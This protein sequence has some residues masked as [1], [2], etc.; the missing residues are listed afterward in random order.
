MRAKERGG[1]CRKERNPAEWLKGSTFGLS[2]KYKIFQRFCKTNSQPE[3]FEDIKKFK[4]YCEG[5][6][7]FA[8]KTFI[9]LANRLFHNRDGKHGDNCF[10]FEL[11]I[12][13]SLHKKISLF[14]L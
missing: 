11:N 9:Q 4:T 5:K 1:M 8:I 14:N 12:L 13:L 2:L 7:G 6:V 3:W 10:L